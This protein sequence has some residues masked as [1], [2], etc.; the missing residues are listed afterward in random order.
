MLKCMC[1]VEATEVSCPDLLQE[2]SLWWHNCLTTSSTPLFFTSCDT[3]QSLTLS[4]S[5]QTEHKEG[6][7]RSTL[8]LHQESGNLRIHRSLEQAFS[9]LPNTL[10]FFLPS[11]PSLSST[12]HRCL[13]CIKKELPWIDPASSM[14]ML[15][16][17]P[18]QPL[19]S[20][21]HPCNHQLLRGLHITSWCEY[22]YS[23]SSPVFKFLLRSYFATCY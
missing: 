14:S 5:W 17:S 23:C 12:F 3:H 8:W 22:S 21:I 6:L 4:C 2:S 15:T 16:Q 19:F 18:P 9:A 10:V 13:L 7:R 1:S 11:V 20:H